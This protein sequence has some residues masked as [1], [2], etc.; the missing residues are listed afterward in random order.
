MALG[1]FFVVVLVAV[2]WYRERQPGPSE[3]ERR[4]F[5]QVVRDSVRMSGD[6]RRMKV[7]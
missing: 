6:W 4:K 2:V 1:L 3:L 7:R 5:A